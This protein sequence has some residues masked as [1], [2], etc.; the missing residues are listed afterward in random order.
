MKYDFAILGGGAAGLSLALELVRSPL[1]EKSILI[2]EKDAKK[3]NDRTWCYWTDEPGPLDDIAYRVWPNMHFRSDSLDRT[4]DLSPLRYQMV[5]G[6]DFYRY[7]EAELEK[8][9]VTFLIGTGE[10]ED[11]G[12][13]ATVR[14]DGQSAQAEWVFDSRIRP[15]DV[16]QNTRRYN[17]LK[18]HFTGWVI[19]T[20]ASSFDPQ[21]VTMFDLR[22]PQ[23]GGV[24]F[25]YILPFSE[26]RA[27]VEYTLFSSDLLPDSD[28]ELA[29]RDYLANNF[30]LR[31]YQIQETEHG[32]IPMTDH[33]FKR[34]LGQRILAIGTRGGRVKPSTGYAFSRIQRDSQRIVSS[35]IQINHPFAI[36][37][38]SLR[39]RFFDTVILEVLAKEPQLGRPIFSAIF[40][41]NPVQRVL[42]FL[43]DSTS[44]WEDLQILSSP[45]PGPFLRALI[46]EVKKLPYNL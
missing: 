28:Y 34:N 39:Y 21:T 42:K 26:T 30:G 14:V 2:I 33:P 25:F 46:R 4:W 11:G 9:N 29:L 22:T 6:V 15:G 45:S 1:K 32:V 18:Q 41:R 12:A 35:L 5:R 36:P 24:T 20:D 8:H 27:L 44:L 7:A 31:R 17:Y 23:R 38:D 43:D 3:S 13:A 40:A 19:E 10:V 37:P 16:V